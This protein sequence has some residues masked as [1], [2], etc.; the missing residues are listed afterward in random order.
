[1]DHCEPRGVQPWWCGLDLHSNSGLPRFST[2]LYCAE[3]SSQIARAILLQQRPNLFHKCAFHFFSW[4]L[5]RHVINLDQ[6][7]LIINAVQRKTTNISLRTALDH[8]LQ[9][10][11]I[12]VHEL[13][14]IPWRS[15][16]HVLFL[17]K[18]CSSL[19]NET[20][21]DQNQGTVNSSWHLWDYSGTRT[22]HTN[23]SNSAKESLYLT[24]SRKAP[25]RFQKRPLNNFK[26]KAIW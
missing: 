22:F 8:T 12:K 13:S 1:M 26:I 6:G 15:L 19:L 21:W 10:Q 17:L 14:R 24:A 11:M 2:A 5:Q 23:V 4:S 20:H 9:S 25:V 7:F 3:S 18:I 16:D